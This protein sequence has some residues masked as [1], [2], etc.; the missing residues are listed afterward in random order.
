MLVLAAGTLKSAGSRI[1]Q[2]TTKHG[3]D[4]LTCRYPNMVLRLDIVMMP[5]Q[6]T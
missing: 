3:L 6:C 2:A 5:I 1:I 4:V